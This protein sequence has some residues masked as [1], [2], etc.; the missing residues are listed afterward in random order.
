MSYTS[1]SIG[2][3]ARGHIFL[4]WAACED[5][6]AAHTVLQQS[7]S[8]AM[9]DKHLVLIG[10][11]AEAWAAGPGLDEAGAGV[12]AAACCLVRVLTGLDVS[13]AGVTEL[14]SLPSE[15]VSSRVTSSKHE[16]E[17]STKC[18]PWIEEASPTCGT[19]ENWST[20]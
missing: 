20:K 4:S 3:Y 14:Q 12:P 13:R 8:V 2:I 1:V 7:R 19:S 9:L 18:L 15:R 17:T 16:S 5:L 10:A 6:D 11:L